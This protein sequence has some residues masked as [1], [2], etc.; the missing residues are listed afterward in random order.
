MQII[1]FFT[2]KRKIIKGFDTD[3]LNWP[4]WPLQICFIDSILL[5]NRIETKP[6]TT[7]TCR[8]KRLGINFQRN[9]SFSAGFNF[10]IFDKSNKSQTRL[11]HSKSHTDADPRTLSKGQI[12]KIMPFCFVFFIEPFWV[13]FVWFWINFWIVVQA[14]DWNE[15]RSSARNYGFGCWKL[16]VLYAFAVQNGKCRIFAKSFWK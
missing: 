3:L 4:Y 11:H 13:K 15:Y 1:W 14:R 8:Q 5:T 2:I 10:I 9:I 12:C 7:N 6:D 16:V